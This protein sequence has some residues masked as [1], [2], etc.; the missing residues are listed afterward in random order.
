MLKYDDY[1][2][3]LKNIYT[4]AEIVN[5]FE[6]HH[7]QNDSYHENNLNQILESVIFYFVL[8]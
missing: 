6:Y 4:L 5:N 2:Q 1:C 3:S 7:H 8:L